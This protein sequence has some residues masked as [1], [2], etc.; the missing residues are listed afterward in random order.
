[1]F[2]GRALTATVLLAALALVGVGRPAA[3]AQAAG[4]TSFKIPARADQLLVVSSPTHDP[5]G[6][7]ATFRSFQRANA[8][9]P[10]R[11]VFPT[12][13]AETGYG[14]LRDSRHEGDG[15]T[16]TG[17]YTFG[18]T[19]YGN[20]PNPGG[21]HERYHHLVCGDWWDEDPYSARY[22]QFV[23]VACGTTPPFASG[24]EALWTETAAY[25]YFAVIDF[26]EH[27]VLGGARAPGSG[28]FLHAWVNGPTA[29]C[30]ALTLPDLLHVLRWLSPAKHPV[31]EIGTNAEVGPVPPAAPH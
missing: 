9:S 27:P 31:I 5:P 2:N 7:I 17:V 14:H 29:G 25:P 3:G 10:W 22:N 13:Q 23:H 26:N 6:Y 1:L 30:V 15:S 12:W 11:A 19:M 24:S 18:P 8:F 28:I 4:A 21:L 16:P 20:E